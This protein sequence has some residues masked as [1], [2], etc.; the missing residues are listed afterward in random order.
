MK[1]AQQMND[2]MIDTLIN[3]CKDVIKQFPQLKE[4]VQGI[5]D[6]CMTEIELG[7]SQT[8]EIELAH[9]SIDELLQTE[10]TIEEHN[11]RVD[12]M[13]KEFNSKNDE[14]SDFIELLSKSRGGQ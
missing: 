1:E 14:P 5:F 12:K 3:R 8:N 13:A 11:A 6:L 10:V 9:F 2:I 7:E 4:E